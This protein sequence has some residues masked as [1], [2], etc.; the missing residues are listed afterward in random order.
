M[1]QFHKQLRVSSIV[2]DEVKFRNI[3]L[4]DGFL[5]R[6]RKLPIADF[7][8]FRITEYMTQREFRKT[9][10]YQETLL[11]CTN[12]PLSTQFSTTEKTVP[13]V[14]EMYCVMN[15]NGERFLQ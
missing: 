9:P 3:I 11:S 1:V 15:M 8:A 12:D 7:S 2:A 13:E 14:A 4:A 10:Y 6:H 5:R